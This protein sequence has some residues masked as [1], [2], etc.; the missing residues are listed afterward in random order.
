MRHLATPVS[1]VLAASVLG[2]VALRDTDLGVLPWALSRASGLVAFAALSA[3]TILGLLIS[4]KARNR[5]LSRPFIF[6]MHQFLAVTALAFM[7]IHA[8]SLLLDGW[9][10]FT[11]ASILVP[12]ASPYRPVA[13]AAGVAA[14]WIAATTTASYWLRSTIGYRRWRALH[15]A[16]F[17]AYF[18]ALAHGIFAG[19]DTGLP[20][21]SWGYVVS[22][23]A[24]AS[25][26]AWRFGIATAHHRQAT[27]GPA[28]NPGR[29][30]TRPG[31]ERHLAKPG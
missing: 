17:A 2:G 12:F 18:A 26:T 19:T 29:S 1:L 8:A 30:T 7:G 21:V 6:N 16:T 23:A 11:L 10:N 13:V 27:H 4:T 24:V 14:A 5:L 31:S 28:M 25:L 9:F 3:A 22:V 15:Y 20:I